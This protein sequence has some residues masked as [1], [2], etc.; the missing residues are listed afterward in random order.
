LLVIIQT[1]VQKK[2]VVFYC[3]LTE[4]LQVERG[5]SGKSSRNA[6]AGSIDT[7]VV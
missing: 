6:A 2:S 4:N 1:G 7:L 5:D 3:F